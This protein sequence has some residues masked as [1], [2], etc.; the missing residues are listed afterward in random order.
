MSRTPHSLRAEVVG[1]IEIGIRPRRAGPGNGTDQQRGALGHGLVV[2]VIE[3]A[4][5]EHCVA[6]PERPVGALGRLHHLLGEDRA[7]TL[8]Q[9]RTSIDLEH[10]AEPLLGRDLVAR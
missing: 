6:G 8:V 4:P 7:L 10:L 2:L 5:V 9:G 3:T 1:G